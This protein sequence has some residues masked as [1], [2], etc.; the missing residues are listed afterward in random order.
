VEELLVSGRLTPG[1]LQE[2]R[3]ELQKRSQGS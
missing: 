3:E 1:Q 2:V